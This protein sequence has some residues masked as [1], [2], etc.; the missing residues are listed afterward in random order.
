MSQDPTA[1]RTET[2]R[3]SDLGELVRTIVLVREENRRLRAENAAL[4]SSLVEAQSGSQ[5]ARESRRAALNLIEDAVEARNLAE[6][7]NRKLLREV[8]ERKQA[9]DSLRAAEEALRQ[10]ELR[11]QTA[12]SAARM[13]TWLWDVQSNRDYLDES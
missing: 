3:E 2:S 4:S 13:G 11:L 8:S 5:A 1:S 10:K 9:E 7:L 6:Q 12:L